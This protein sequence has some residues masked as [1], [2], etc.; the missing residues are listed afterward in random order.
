MTQLLPP[1]HLDSA[2]AFLA[3]QQMPSWCNPAK[4]VL[5]LRLDAP[6]P[7]NN[8]IRAMHFHTYKK[9]RNDMAASVAAALGSHKPRTNPLT[10]LFIVRRSAGS[11]DWDNAIEGGL[12]PL[13]D[14]LIR[15][16]DRNPDGLGII[17]EYPFASTA[18][19]SRLFFQGA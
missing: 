16:S 5:C 6:S 4:L 12:K 10:A 14:C 13:L 11:L 2:R 1:P 7:S 19:P 17:E 3:E 8:V 18:V 15:A 9:L